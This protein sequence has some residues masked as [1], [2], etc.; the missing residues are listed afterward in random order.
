[1]PRPSVPLLVAGALLA[2]AGC[3]QPRAEVT[4]RPPADADAALTKINA[5]LKRLDQ[6]LSARD[7]LVSFRFRDTN[8]QD[9]R[10][11]GHP[12]RILYNQPQCL[13]FDIRSIVGL[14]AHIGS[15][16]E[17]YWFWVDTEDTVKLWY[18]S[19]AALEAGAAAEV[20]LPPDRLLAA[21]LWQPLP[22]RLRNGS[23]PMLA[24]ARVADSTA[25]PT[26]SLV[27]LSVAGPDGWPYV[28]R[29]IQ[30][31][32][33]SGLPTLIRDFDADGQVLMR[34]ELRDYRPMGQAPEP[35]PLTPRRYVVYW[36][37]Q[38]AEMRLDIGTLEFTDRVVPCDFP[39]GWTG[40]RENLDRLSP[41][42]IPNEPPP[43][44]ADTPPA[45]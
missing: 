29:E 26:Q 27:Y 1:M 2:L 39:E 23:R 3:T 14:V 37:Q 28:A 11:V 8:G 21:L 43:P 15:N 18:G 42:K 9:R 36:P 7:A 41:A 22:E 6:P 32:Q 40:E 33:D 5:N 34:A 16:D 20:A 25:P 17:R 12:A 45:S 38:Q 31:D 4:Y 44:N 35:A 24:E 19:W 30:L 13:Y 10:F